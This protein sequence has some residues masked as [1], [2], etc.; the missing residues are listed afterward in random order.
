[1]PPATGYLVVHQFELQTQKKSCPL[2]T[3]AGARKATMEKCWGFV[4]ASFPRKLR[5]YRILAACLFEYGTN[6]LR[7]GLSAI[8]RE[9]KLRF[10]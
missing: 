10:R 7:L 2:E 4:E 3:R 5:H 1:M 6:G 8:L 9:C